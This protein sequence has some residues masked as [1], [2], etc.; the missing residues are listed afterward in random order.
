MDPRL[1]ASLGLLALMGLG[2]L[3]AEVLPAL[4][5]RKQPGQQPTISEVGSPEDNARVVQA[6]RQINTRLAQDG[7]RIPERVAI[8]I[9]QQRTNW[10]GDDHGNLHL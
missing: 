7:K 1:L 9:I 3:I 6:I 2:I 5:R 10:Q 4:R 8:D